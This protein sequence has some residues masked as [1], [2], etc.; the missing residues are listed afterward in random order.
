MG[1]NYKTPCVFIYIS[2]SRWLIAV[3]LVPCADTK[4]PAMSRAYTDYGQ[5]SMAFVTIRAKPS[6]LAI[7][8][9]RGS[10]R[11]NGE[12]GRESGQRRSTSVVYRAVNYFTVVLELYCGG[13]RDLKVPRFSPLTTPTC[14]AWKSSCLIGITIHTRDGYT[15]RWERFNS[16]MTRRVNHWT[17]KAP[18][19]NKPLSPARNYWRCNGTDNAKCK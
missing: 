1:A 10:A 14:A 16:N 11:Y 12:E 3:R 2:L 8:T 19:R 13:E 6:S 5:S 4:L 17:R 9:A 7:R 15:Y 18:T